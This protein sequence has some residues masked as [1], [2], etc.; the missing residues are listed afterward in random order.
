MM[1]HLTFIGMSRDVKWDKHV[2][3]DIVTDPN[4]PFRYLHNVEEEDVKGDKH[5][6]EDN[7]D[8][9]ELAIEM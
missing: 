7:N 5:V 1:F 2:W 3:E 4:D 9:D 8:Y 6:W